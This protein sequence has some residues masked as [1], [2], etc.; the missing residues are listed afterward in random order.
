MKTATFAHIFDVGWF[1]SRL[2]VGMEF[3]ILPYRRCQEITVSYCLVG[4]DAVALDQLLEI[5]FLKQYSKIIHLLWMRIW[6]ERESSILDFRVDYLHRNSSKRMAIGWPCQPLA[7]H[8]AS[9]RF[10]WSSYW[11]SGGWAVSSARQIAP[12]HVHDATSVTAAK[13]KRYYG[14]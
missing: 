11:Q 3:K 2:P 1:M 6:D 7:D 8:W 13:R 14:V 10:A 5:Y 4:S 12:H 9:R